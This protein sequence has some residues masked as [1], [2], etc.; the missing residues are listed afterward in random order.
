M[1]AEESKIEMG[2]VG[3][4]SKLD[5]MGGSA[6]SASK[7]KM[8]TF[9]AA[10]TVGLSSAALAGEA[11]FQ[12]V[13]SNVDQPTDDLYGD[14]KIFSPG[15]KYTAYA[16]E[17]EVFTFGLLVA[18]FSISYDLQVPEITR[19]TA[20]LCT[21]LSI[22]FWI[23]IHIAEPS[24]NWDNDVVGIPVAPAGG[25]DTE[26]RREVNFWMGFVVPN[27]CVSAMALCWQ[28]MALFNLYRCQ[29]D[30]H[31]NRDPAPNAL[32]Y[33][34]FSFLVFWV[35]VGIL[36]VAGWTRTEEGPYRLDSPVVYPPTVIVYAPVAIISGLAVVAYGLTNMLYAA[37][38]YTVQEEIW[39]VTA[40]FQLLSVI[41]WC[42]LL[43]FH[44]A[45]LLIPVVFGPVYYMGFT[46]GALNKEK[47][48]GQS[49][50]TE[51]LRGR[52]VGGGQ[53]YVQDATQKRKVKK[54]IYIYVLENLIEPERLH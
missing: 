37:Y 32:R 34:W 1:K 31:A 17:T 24:F 52:G 8:N 25:W 35:G 51:R 46:V 54:E 18:I 15:L 50:E 27:A 14:S 28:N 33:G 16:F 6:D 48:L 20:W 12:F 9:R 38:L 36:T 45:L 23:V 26:F 40:F 7:I 53:L 43:G 5:F 44:Y 21:G 47:P 10:A 3:R 30:E 29:T 22:F 39:L 41:A 11:I 4:Q 19:A 2:S 42:W 49:T 13:S